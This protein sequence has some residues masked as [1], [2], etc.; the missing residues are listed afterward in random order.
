MIKESYKELQRGSFDDFMMAVTI[1]LGIVACGVLLYI[2]YFTGP[3]CGGL[4]G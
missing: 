2:G 3:T 1:L 4:C